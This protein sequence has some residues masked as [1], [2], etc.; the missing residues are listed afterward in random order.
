[1]HNKFLVFG[2][3][4]TD[5]VGGDGY[6]VKFIPK[7]VWTGSFNFTKNAGR[8]FENVVIINNAKI[9]EAYSCEFAQIFALSEE[10]DWKSSWIEPI[11]RVGT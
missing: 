2:E 11:F 9:A 4:K 1:M 5:A 7:K 6:P 10:L 3:F 8:S